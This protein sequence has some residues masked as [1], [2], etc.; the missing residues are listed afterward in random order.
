MRV[1]AATSLLIEPALC[2]C[3]TLAAFGQCPF[4]T[5][6]SKCSPPSLSEQQQ[7]EGYWSDGNCMLRSRA[8][9]DTVLQQNK[10]WVDSNHKSGAQAD[11]SGARLIGSN[12]ENAE[13]KGAIL[14]GAFLVNTDLSG[15]DLSDAQLSGAT[16]EPVELPLMH[17][18]YAHSLELLTYCQWPDPLTQLRKKFQDAGYR[19]QERA[20]SCAL[21]RRQ[22]ELAPVATERWFKWLAFDLTCEYG[23]S[24]GRPLRIVLWLW[25]FFGVIY[26]VL[27]HLPGTSG[28]YFVGTR[29]WRGRTNT[30][31]IQIR[32][33][34]IP[35]AKSWKKPFLLLCRE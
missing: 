29:T 18:A 19:E 15:A 30:Q 13:L 5:T 8:E 11:L 12:L 25:L 9:L 28:I 14:V 27:M 4:D 17:I 26:A 33:E 34:A 31:G 1:R 23:F 3:S 7:K 16:F 32:P 22:A 35:P 24:P 21:N 2:L 10:L 6:S 20:I